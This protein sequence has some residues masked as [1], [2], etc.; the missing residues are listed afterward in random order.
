MLADVRGNITPFLKQYNV[1]LHLPNQAISVLYENPQFVLSK[2]HNKIFITMSFPLS[3]TS[4]PMTLFKVISLKMPT[5]SKNQHV[6]FIKE[7]PQFVA[8][9]QTQKWFLEFL[10]MPQ[11]SRD[12]LYLIQHNPTALK[13]RMN[14]TCF[15][16]VVEL[17]REGIQRLCQLVIQPYAAEPSSNPRGW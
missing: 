6:S 11:V 5:D 9:D 12:G 8:Y 10:S 13:H 14:P 17:D 3:I 1:P 2:R 15:L 16:A 4:T 7:L